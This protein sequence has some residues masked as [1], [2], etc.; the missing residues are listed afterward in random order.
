MQRFG[1][2]IVV[3]VEDLTRSDDGEPVMTMNNYRNLV[4]RK[5][6]NILRPGKGLG[7]CAL[8]E[9]PS[10]PE[11]FRHKFEAKYGDPEELLSNNKPMITINATARQFFAGLEEGSF[12]LPNG[13]RLP[14]EKIEEYTL[15]ASVLDVLVEKV[16][17]QRIGRNRLKNSTRIIWENILATAEQMRNDFH[18][19]LPE[20]AAR[21][22]DKL[23]AYEREGFASLVSK[24]F[25]NA[26]KSKITPE[27]G[28]LL[29]ALR[30]SRIPVYTL[31]QY[32]RLSAP[33]VCDP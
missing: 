22:K 14:A 9:Y 11:R 33:C 16:Q 31:R 19:T 27:G 7:C 18:H 3:T 20:N 2:T 29:V 23:R 28:R 12:R 25:C 26:N 24:K 1:H 10:L 17:E 15:N 21:L 30:R 32:E 6:L 13:E 8:I 5:Q 4:R